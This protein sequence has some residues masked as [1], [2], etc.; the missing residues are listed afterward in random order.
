MKQWDLKCNRNAGEL[1][2]AA[3]CP[4]LLSHVWVMVTG[5]EVR[6]LCSLFCVCHDSQGHDLF[7]S[8]EMFGLIVS[9]EPLV[10]NTCITL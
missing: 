9:A 10:V 2:T 5:L 6:R 4:W 7:L 3:L 8:L 1:T